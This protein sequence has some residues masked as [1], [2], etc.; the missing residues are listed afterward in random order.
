M[1]SGRAA[2]GGSAGGLAGALRDLRSRGELGKREELHG[3]GGDA[4][5]D[6]RDAVKAYGPSGREIKLEYH[7]EFGRLLTQKEAYR[8]MSHKFHGTGPGKRKTEKRLRQLRE[9]EMRKNE[10]GAETMR[11]LENVT[12]ATGKAY[13]V[14]DGNDRIGSSRR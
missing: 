12:A 14:V 13:V 9:E 7:D 3:R 6:Y 2:A 10:R 1:C 8:H 4:R 11:A 5:Y